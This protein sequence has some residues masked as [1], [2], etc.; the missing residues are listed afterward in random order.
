MMYDLPADFDFN[1]L[2]GKSLDLVCFGK[3]KMDLHL[4]GG[5]LIGV[6][7]DIS[8]DSGN[9]S[10]LPDALSLV[11]TLINQEITAASREGAGVLALTFSQ[12]SVLRIHDSSK[13]FECY[14]ISLKGKILAI[15]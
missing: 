12:G 1:Q 11:Y 10:E 2:V 6:E 9:L 7:D 3:F 14:S 15:V 13:Q 5:Y 8:L 4:S